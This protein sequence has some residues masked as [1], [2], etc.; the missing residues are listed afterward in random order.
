MA[1]RSV[2]LGKLDIDL[3]G[4]LEL[5]INGSTPHENGLVLYLFLYG[6]I[7]NEVLLQG[8]AP[9]K[10]K[11]IFKAYISLQEAFVR[12]ENHEKTPIFSFVLS[13]DSEN[14]TDYIKQR[15]SLLRNDNI[16]KQSYMNNN[17]LEVS[18]KLS[19]DLIFSN[20]KKR[21]K[22]ISEVFRFSVADSFYSEETI[23]LEDNIILK[24]IERAENIT[25]F[26]TFEFIKSL[27]LNEPQKI[28]YIYDKVRQKYEQ[29]NA[30]GCESS[31]D[32]ETIQFQIKNIIKYIKVIGLDKLL[33][34]SEALKAPLLFKLRK[35]AS[36]QELNNFYFECQEQKDIDDFF[37]LILA[38]NTDKS[39]RNIMQQSPSDLIPLIFEYTSEFIPIPKLLSKGFEFIFKSSSNE[40]TK[41]YYE[42]KKFQIFTA[43]ERLHRDVESLI[44]K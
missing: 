41:N 28:K 22:S 25:F 21:T 12:N 33:K 34:R 15:F 1:A 18:R 43:S 20:V 6:L 26:Q 2:Y 38:V 24:A 29:S 7:A 3:T 32:F 35:L 19:S 36:L 27:E 17:A 42:Q 9:L 4:K 31:C 40:L 37:D 23:I 13:N 30:F 8:S 44:N 11:N 14:Y 39:L 5:K 16:E 10:I